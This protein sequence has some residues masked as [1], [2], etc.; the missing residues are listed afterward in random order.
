METGDKQRQNASNMSKLSVTAGSFNNGNSYLASDGNGPQ[1]FVSSSSHG[2]RS[3]SS[4]G[5]SNKTRVKQIASSSIGNG[6]DPSLATFSSSSRLYRA[7]QP[8]I[9]RYQNIIQGVE[10]VG[11]NYTTTTVSTDRS[12]GTRRRRRETQSTGTIGKSI[13]KNQGHSKISGGGSDFSLERQASDNSLTLD[14]QQSN[15]GHEFDYNSDVEDYVVH[16]NNDENDNPS[17]RS[18]NDSSSTCRNN[19]SKSLLSSQSNI[20]TPRRY[21]FRHSSHSTKTVPSGNT[22]KSCLHESYPLIHNSSFHN[23]DDDSESFHY[24]SDIPFAE[25]DRVVQSNHKQQYRA[26]CKFLGMNKKLNSKSHSSPSS[27]RYLPLRLSSCMKN[28][29]S[30]FRPIGTIFR[31][32][33]LLFMIACGLITFDARKTITEHR[34][35]ILLYDEERAHILEQ[36]T[37]IDNAAKRVHSNYY[38]KA[39]V[40][41]GNVDDT[42]NALLNGGGGKTTKLDPI[43]SSNSSAILRKRKDELQQEL[44][45]IQVKIQINARDRIRQ[46]FGDKPI[47]IH[48]PLRFDDENDGQSAEIEHLVI[49][50][51]DDTPHAASTLLQQVKKKLWDS[52]TYQRV[53]SSVNPISGELS[54]DEHQLDCIQISPKVASINLSPSLEFVEK[55]RGCHHPGSV[56]IHQLESEDFHVMVLKVH[57]SEES[58][59]IHHD[60]GDVCIGTV[61]EGLNE[62][63]K[64][65]PSLPVIRKEDSI[66]DKGNEYDKIG[67]KLI[68]SE[69][70]INPGPIALALEE[71]AVNS[72]N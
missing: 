52:V 1:S 71:D 10:I 56:S 18:I 26:W 55:S 41:N 19:A 42:R 40:A 69:N 8:S 38:Q 66:D 32:W 54:N 47:H 65:L 43:E 34:L 72:Y 2:T 20:M 37:W 50:L 28:S 59:A 24:Q 12:G 7:P 15:S 64:R 57:I 9:R 36:M 48:L 30:T 14:G 67:R 29:C 44:D 68:Q 60:E 16:T 39:V 58:Q 17:R 33:Q 6:S 46:Q 3:I 35:Q 4:S 27:F 70:N 23:N 61:I 22:S 53:V 63:V 11:H 25:N 62:L 21:G 51:W 13:N 31:W 5:R 49:A 45:R